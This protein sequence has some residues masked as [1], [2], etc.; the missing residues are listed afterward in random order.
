MDLNLHLLRLFFTVVEQ[1]G[2]SRAAEILFISQP[3]VSKAVRE[4][5]RQ[6][7]LPL[8]ERGV[9]GPRVSRGVRLTESGRALFEHARGI[10][11]LERAA[12]E[13]VRSRVGRERGRVAIGAS[14]TIAGYWLPPYITRFC[15]RF[16]ALNLQVVVG[17][18]QSIS[19][20]LLD[21]AI[22][23]ALVEGPV[24]DARIA[25]L[26]WQVD[27]L[28]I[29][30]P[31]NSPLA[32]RRMVKAEELNSQTWF[33]REPGSGT[34]EVTRH[35]LGKERINPR[36]TIEIGSNEAIAR[37]VAGGGLA[38]LPAV[39]VQ[40]LLALGKVKALRYS[41]NKAFS[42]PLFRLELKDRPLSPAASAFR[43]LLA[44]STRR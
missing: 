26:D 36:Q 6:L 15:G 33:V 31:V 14:T 27:T 20:K 23:L 42:R 19:E 21:C 5:E 24:E 1:R 7:D 17:N 30:A 16:P 8:I 34:G 40:D 13:D 9:S 43:D 22:D 32:N 39:V 4:L 25:S 37:A 41:G 3:A 44:E 18:T 28:L 10:F 12:L 2:F 29:V 11:A 38:M 35:L